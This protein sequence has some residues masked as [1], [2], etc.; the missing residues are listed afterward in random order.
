MTVGER[1]K[2]RRIALGW[3]QEELAEKMGYKGRTSVCVAENKDDNVTITKISKF[4]KALGCTTAY[5][6]G[7]EDINGN[8]IPQN[9]P[10][11]KIPISA[12]RT[13]FVEEAIAVYRDIQQLTPD[14]KKALQEYLQYLKSQS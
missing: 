5:L 9:Y 11:I 3:T 10:D 8:P 4:A 7:M 12:Y 1:I 14:R 13:E 6:M 2:E